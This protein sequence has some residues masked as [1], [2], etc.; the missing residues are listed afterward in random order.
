MMYVCVWE[1]VIGRD[2][3]EEHKGV[4]QVMGAK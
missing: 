3:S 4:R 2:E 1:L